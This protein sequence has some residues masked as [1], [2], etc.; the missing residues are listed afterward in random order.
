MKVI[1]S[2]GRLCT[3]TVNMCA[4]TL[5][6]YGLW[7]A[8]AD[9]PQTAFSIPLL[10]LFVCLS[11]ECQVSVEGFCNTLRWKNNLTLAEVNTLYRALV[12]ESI[13]HFRHH[14]FRQRSLVDICPQLDD[15][16]IC[17]A[18]PKADG[19]M[20]VTLDA[21][22]GLVRKQSSGTSVVEPLHGTRMFV[23]EKDVEE[24]LL[25]HL[26]SSKPHEDCSNFKAGNMLRSQ[27]QAKKLDVTGVFGASCHH[28][29]PLMFVNMSQG[30]RL[31]Y[32]LYVIDELLRRCEDKNIHLRVVYDIACVVASHLHKSGEGIPHNIS[33]A[34]PAFHVYGHKLPCQIKYSTRR[35]DGF[36]LTDGEGME[37]LWSFLQRFARVTKEMTPSHRLDLLTDALLHYG[38]RKSTDLGLST[39]DHIQIA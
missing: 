28:E 36:G 21:N 15:G 2:T 23:D 10:E 20:I 9:K 11:L 26:D 17:P 34:V 32:P 8:S 14:H 31:A 38:R 30:E 6:R 4:C 18:C 5:L 16:T 37:R 35:L 33:L 3:V 19:D 22:F 25:S 27:K 1:V 24:Y 7:P 29:M 13:S 12:G 39:A